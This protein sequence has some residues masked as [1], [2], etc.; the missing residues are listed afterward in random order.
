MLR[1]QV[2]IINYTAAGEP[3]E[4]EVH[5]D[6]LKAPHGAVMAFQATSIVLQRPGEFSLDACL[7]ETRSPT[8]PTAS[9]AN[10]KEV[11]GATGGDMQSQNRH[12]QCFLGSLP[13]D[14]LLMTSLKRL[15]QQR[16]GLQLVHQ[17]HKRLALQ[18]HTLP[19]APIGKPRPLISHEFKRSPSHLL[20]LN[21]R[22][23]S[24]RLATW[25]GMHTAH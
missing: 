22:T 24:Q 9:P 20:H 23:S 11:N 7:E 13:P 12:L 21:Q 5:V 15:V 1:T 6:V 3:F 19:L 18:R 14:S 8:V 10:G 25:Q 17:R 2:P 4:H 16:Y